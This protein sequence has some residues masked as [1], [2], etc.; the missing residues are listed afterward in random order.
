[1]SGKHGR[2]KFGRSAAPV[3]TTVTADRRGDLSSVNAAPAP[4]ASVPPA[5][6]YPLP[7]VPPTPPSLPPIRSTPLPEFQETVTEPVLE[8]ALIEV[9]EIGR[10]HV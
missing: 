10:A 6:V 9:P 2:G 3:G 4:V 1:M 7:L 8:S 5:V